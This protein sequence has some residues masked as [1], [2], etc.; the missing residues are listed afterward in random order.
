MAIN[1]NILP[2]IV[3]FWGILD[4]FLGNFSPYLRIFCQFIEIYLTVLLKFLS[5]F[6]DFQGILPLSD[7]FDSFIEMFDILTCIKS[8]FY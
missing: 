3:T 8:I 6:K 2:L 4:V 7:I 1:R 5:I